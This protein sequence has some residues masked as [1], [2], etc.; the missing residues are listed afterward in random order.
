MSGKARGVTSQKRPRNR[1]E[2]CAYPFH[3]DSRR[4]GQW[5]DSAQ[6]GAARRRVRLSEASQ[7]LVSGCKPRHF[8]VV[9]ATVGLNDL[10]RVEQVA[11][12]ALCCCG[13]VIEAVSLLGVGWAI[14]V[15]GDFRGERWWLGRRPAHE[16]G[17]LKRIREGVESRPR[18]VQ[19]SRL[20]RGHSVSWASSCRPGLSSVRGPHVAAPAA[21]HACSLGRRRR[22]TVGRAAIRESTWRCSAAFVIV[23]TGRAAWRRGGACRRN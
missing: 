14:R 23:V 10:A 21:S 1:F 11:P 8:A 18:D 9:A 6:S 3:A 17:A 13:V 12:V 16:L 15:W 19:A 2:A 22:P 20:D 5:S 4:F 7:L